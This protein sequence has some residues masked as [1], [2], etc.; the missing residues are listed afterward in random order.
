MGTRL[1]G[2]SSSTFGTQVGTFQHH[3]I[4][5]SPFSTSTASVPFLTAHRRRAGLT[6]HGSGGYGVGLTPFHSRHGL[7][8]CHQ[9]LRDD[10]TYGYPSTRW[11]TLAAEDHA[12]CFQRRAPSSSK[13]T[14]GMVHRHGR[15]RALE[16]ADLPPFNGARCWRCT[17]SWASTR[18]SVLRS[19]SS[20]RRLLDGLAASAPVRGLGGALSRRS[21]WLTWLPRRRRKPRRLRPTR[22]ATDRRRARRLPRDAVRACAGVFQNLSTASEYQHSWREIK[23][24]AAAPSRRGAIQH[25]HWGNGGV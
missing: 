10:G 6:S 11:A 18:C 23:A 12:G 20:Q 24:S 7:A 5:D 9:I 14:L 22:R 4:A 13:R 17:T 1:R 25:K 16:I 19:T 8:L 2:D 3:V 21:R 15:G